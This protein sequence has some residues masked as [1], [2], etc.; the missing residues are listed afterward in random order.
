MGC[1]KSTALRFLRALGWETLEADQIAKDLLGKDPEV[2]TALQ[3][4][5]GEEVFNHEGGVD[6]QALARVV[7]RDREELEALEKILH[8]R[9]RLVWQREVK[10]KA[11][12]L[13]MVEIPLLFEKNLEKDFDFTVCIGCA[14]ATQLQ[15]LA[16]RGFT[17]EDV[18][19][20]LTHQLPLA[21]KIK[22]AD[23]SLTN[24]GTE[25]FLSIQID[26]LHSF[27]LERISH[28]SHV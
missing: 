14:H 27:I 4:R 7:F 12:G 28:Q 10:A 20:R 6:R 13:L 24:D 3:E 1:G 9:V 8:P 26:L 21:E 15:R 17:A 19:A 5:W 16:G 23:F 22:R 18:K 25:A 2:Q 11:K